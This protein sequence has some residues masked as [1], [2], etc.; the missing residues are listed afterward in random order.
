MKIEE[1]I[2]W[3]KVQRALWKCNWTNT[4]QGIDY[5][6]KIDEAIDNV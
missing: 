4:S 2:K 1:Q 3:A 6:T 5:W